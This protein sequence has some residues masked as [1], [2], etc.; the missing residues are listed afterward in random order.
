MNNYQ[1]KQNIKKHIRVLL[2][3]EYDKTTILKYIN[4]LYG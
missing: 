2:L 3:E 1:V 4:E